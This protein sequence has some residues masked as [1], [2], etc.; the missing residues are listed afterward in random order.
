MTT[1]GEFCGGTGD[2]GAQATKCYQN[3]KAGLP[4][5]GDGF[6]HVVK[7]TNFFID[8]SHL[9]V[10][11]EVRNTFVNTKAPPAPTPIQVGRPA[12]HG[13]L[14]Q[15]RARARLPDNAAYRERGHAHPRAKTPPEEPTRPPV[16]PQHA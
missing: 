3:I 4:T 5:V 2:F 6:K 12:V 1:G 9:P 16:P 11:F 7:I 10:F 14:F 13:A 15:F 8:M